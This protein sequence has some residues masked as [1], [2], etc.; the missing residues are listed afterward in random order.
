MSVTPYVVGNWVRGEKFYGRDTLIEEILHGPRNCLWVLGTRRI[1]KTSLL[2]Q[3]E[4]LTLATPD[5]GYFPIFWNFQGASDPEDLHEEFIEALR[6]HEERLELLGIEL[7]DVEDN[8]LS[9]TMGRLRRKLAPKGFKLLLLCDEVEELITLKQK[10]PSLLSKLRR[11]MQ[12]NEDIRSVLT[13]TIRLWAL[14]DERSDTSQF[15]HGFTPPLFIHTLSDEATKAL[16]RQANLPSDSRPKFDDETVELIRSHCDNHPY[17]VQLV[18]KRFAEYGNL[19]ESINQ[20]ATDPMV[21]YFFA[22]DF[23]MLSETERSI[24]RVIAEHSSSTSNSIQDSVFVEPDRL[25]GRLYRLEHLGYIRRNKER[26]F[27]LVNYFFRRW[28]KELTGENGRSS[29]RA[30]LPTTAIAGTDQTTVSIPDERALFG[31]R[32]EVLKQ[33]G[34]GATGVVYKA[35]DKDL[36]VDIAIKLLRQEYASHPEALERFRQEIVFSRDV[37]HPNILRIYDLGQAG[38]KRYLTMQWVEGPTLAQF[39]SDRGALSPTLAVT[40]ARKLAAAVE[41][42]HG[43]GVLHRDIKPQ[44][45]LLNDDEPLLT[46]FGLVRLLG[47]TGMTRTGVFLG[48]PDYASPEQAKMLP[49]D[50]K[51]DI[52]ALGLVIFEMATGRRAFTGRSTREILEMH[53]NDPPPNP[54]DLRPRIPADLSNLILRCL[55]KE[56]GQRYPSAAALRQA[57]ERL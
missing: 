48:T 13:S 24:L 9:R 34:K 54:M 11:V 29:A 26:Q 3:I 18:G 20:V 49:L 40:V 16:I 7:S 35:R 38:D 22:V 23:E 19:Q 32:Y 52:Y 15:L 41:A 12:S 55:E 8:N 37:V 43:A 33:V 25:T 30:D 46:D 10:D 27:V 45:I 5:L 4:H 44:N 50:E 28:F 14:V 42:L 39:I 51:S 47:R 31:E 2:K 21:S 17:L 57:L 1:G 6:D 53:K 36:K 56:P